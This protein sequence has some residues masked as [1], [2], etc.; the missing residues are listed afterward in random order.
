MYH[1]DLIF[2]LGENNIS[3]YTL[4]S[5]QTSKETTSR[6]YFFLCLKVAQNEVSRLCDTEYHV[7]V[8]VSRLHDC[9]TQM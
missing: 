6:R 2:Y 4:L 3:N 7:S 9:I 8:M 5:W 1:I